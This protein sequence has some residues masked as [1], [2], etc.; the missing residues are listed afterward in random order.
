MPTYAYWFLVEKIRSW[1]S[2]KTQRGHDDISLP[3]VIKEN[4]RD[5]GSIDCDV[6]I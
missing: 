5:H 6:E 2:L 3:L 1:Q 4:A